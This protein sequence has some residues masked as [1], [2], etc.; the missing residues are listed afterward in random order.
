MQF[1]R[2]T[3]ALVRPGER[4]VCFLDAHRVLCVFSP[5]SF[6]SPS[7]VQGGTYVV[8]KAFL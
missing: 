6:G 7:W 2:F 4:T 3:L 8:L 1:D 5:S